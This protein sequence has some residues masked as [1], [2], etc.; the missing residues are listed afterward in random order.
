ME[1]YRI[2]KVKFLGATDYTG[3]RVKIYETKRFNDDK[4]QSKV[5]SYDYA[6]GNI[7]QQAIGILKENGFNIVGTGSEFDNYYIICDNWGE[8]FKE[9]KNLR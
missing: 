2:I 3:S 6:V 7:L 1:N 9:I 5:F 4:T 8:N